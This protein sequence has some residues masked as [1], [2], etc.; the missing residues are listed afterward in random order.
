MVSLVPV[1]GELG[2]RFGALPTS[3]RGAGA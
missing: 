2:H 1:S 3:Q